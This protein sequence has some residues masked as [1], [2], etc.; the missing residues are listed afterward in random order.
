MLVLRGVATASGNQPKDTLRIATEKV[1]TSLFIW[2][3]TVKLN[4][5]LLVLFQ[6]KLAS[7]RNLQ[8]V[9][10]TLIGKGRFGK[11]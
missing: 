3:E 8:E 11:Y 9:F 6:T 2:S 10:S 5:N 1:P 7:L 4:S